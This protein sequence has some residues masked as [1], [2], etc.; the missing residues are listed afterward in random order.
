MCYTI[1]T[2][3]ETLKLKGDTKMEH[4]EYMDTILTEYADWLAY[5]ADMETMTDPIP[6]EE[7]MDALAAYF[8]VN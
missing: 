6:S 1:I 3:R 7:D 2:E 8:G 4:F 5:E